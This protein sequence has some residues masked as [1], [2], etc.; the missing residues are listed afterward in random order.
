MSEDQ[1]KLTYE[2]LF[3]ILRREK[4]RGELQELDNTFFNDFSEYLLEK[5]EII[6]HENEQSKLFGEQEKL[7]TLNELANIKK[8]I[9]EL[10]EK[11]ERKIVDLVINK[12][13]T[14]S[15]IASNPNLLP[16]EEPLHDA[17]L[18]VLDENRKSVLHSVIDIN[19]IKMNKSKSEPTKNLK[20]IKFKEEIPKFVGKELEPYGPFKTDDQAPIPIEIAE[21]L[22]KQDKAEEIQIQE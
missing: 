18:K 3:E 22:I 11:R 14:N 13:R 17:L 15:T 20:M 5:S 7:K 12:S 2:T 21:I 4:N 8:I 1:I 10:Y 19:K 6:E 16:E 9:K